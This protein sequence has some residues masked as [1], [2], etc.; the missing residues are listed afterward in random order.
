M[1]LSGLEL[2]VLSAACENNVLRKRQLSFFILFAGFIKCLYFMD[3][4]LLK[5]TECEGYAGKV[6]R[7]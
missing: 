2:K 6:D 3:F 4:R 7:I 1:R 5:T